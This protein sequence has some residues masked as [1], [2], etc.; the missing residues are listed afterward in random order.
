MKEIP[1]T[2]GRVALVDSEDYHLVSGRKWCCSNGA[3]MRYERGLPTYMARLIMGAPG[4]MEVDHIN[5]NR[6]DNRRANLRLCTHKQN[7]QNRKRQAGGS[8]RYK[9]VHK[10]VGKWRAMIGY[11]GK[12][13]HLGYFADEEDAAKAYN[14]AASERFGEFA[15]LNVISTNE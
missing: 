15:R 14:E 3:A 12:L 9:G 5:G 11:D 13:Y 7:L 8:S 2:Q 4:G 1:V 6:L 10:S